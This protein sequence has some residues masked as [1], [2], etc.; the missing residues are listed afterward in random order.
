MY[1]P[2]FPRTQQGR[3][4]ATN[5]MPP[6]A[7]SNPKKLATHSL[8]VFHLLPGH[9]HRICSEFLFEFLTLSLPLLYTHSDT[10]RAKET[11]IQ[12]TFILNV[13]S[14]KQSVQSAA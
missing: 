5:S 4:F 11:K 14:L 6:S 2:L 1:L 3:P 9:H 13:G 12:I 7:T 10:L 8:S